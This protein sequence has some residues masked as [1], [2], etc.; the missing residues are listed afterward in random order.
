MTSE[1][2]PP[3]EKRNSAITIY[4]VATILLTVV[5]LSFLFSGFSARHSLVVRGMFF[6]PG[7]SGWD[8]MSS[9]RLNEWRERGALVLQQ[10]ATDHIFNFCPFAVFV[11]FFFLNVSAH[12]VAALVTY[13]AVCS[14]IACYFF[15]QEV[16]S[17]RMAV[18]A[19]LLAICTSYPFAYLFDRG[20]IEGT[21]WPPIAAGVYCFV[22]KHYLAAALL[23]AIAASIKPFPSMLF[24]LFLPKRRYPEFFVG[25][26][27]V[28]IVSVASLSIIGPSFSVALRENLRGFQ[29]VTERYVMLYRVGEIGA[30]HSLF[31][32]V[33]QILRALAGWPRPEALAATIRRIYPYYQALAVAIFV[34]AIVRLRN[35][36]TLNQVFGIFV[37]MLLISPVNYDYT[38]IAMYIPWA[39]LLLTLSRPGC[40]LPPHAASLLMICCAILFTSQYYLLFGY[41]ASFGGQVKTLA[42]LAILIVSAIYPLPSRFSRITRFP[43]PRRRRGGVTCLSVRVLL[44]S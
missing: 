11:I 28:A 39:I 12:P 40:A 26:G 25:I 19:L 17:N 10:P 16:R 2:S 8:L 9:T 34:A 41:W 21:L 24:L 15:W 44:F 13:V 27:A 23:F 6:A 14:L 38:L 20:N 37:L 36:P 7:P 3:L 43:M 18:L 33:K 42:L 31:S 35:L 22:R 32:L 1:A 29:L 4:L 5:A 30:D